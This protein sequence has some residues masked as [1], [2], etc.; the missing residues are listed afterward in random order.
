M[1]T[2]LA[3]SPL[4]NFE[5]KATDLPDGWYLQREIYCYGNEL[6]KI[7]KRFGVPMQEVTNQFILAGGKWM[8]INYLLCARPKDSAA[9]CKKMREMS[10]KENIILCRSGLITEIISGSMEPKKQAEQILV[11]KIDKSS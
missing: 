8:Q 5:L 4:Q 2:L 9:A 3:V 7:G 11:K 1:L 6:A 10:G